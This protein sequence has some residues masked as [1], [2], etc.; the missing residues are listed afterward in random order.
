VLSNLRTTI[1]RLAGLGSSSVA[2]ELEDDAVARIGQ[3]W[4]APRE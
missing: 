2:P 3:G 4:R 1:D